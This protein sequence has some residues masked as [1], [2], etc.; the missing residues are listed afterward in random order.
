[1]RF[2]VVV[3]S[4]LGLLGGIAVAGDE[5]WERQNLD[6]AFR[7][8][9]VAAADVNHDGKIDVLAGDVWYEAPDWK[10]HEIRKPGKFVAGARL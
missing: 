3:L 6:G 7:S 10:M 9:G 5:A 8:E 4:W 2:C 1:M